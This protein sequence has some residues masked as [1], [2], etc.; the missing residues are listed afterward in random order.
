MF[1]NLWHQP[2]LARTGMIRRRMKSPVTVTLME[3]ATLTLVAVACWP[4]LMGEYLAGGVGLVLVAITM[5]ALF[6]AR[7]RELA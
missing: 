5:G 6:A 7:R 1:V 2:R 4:L 3:L